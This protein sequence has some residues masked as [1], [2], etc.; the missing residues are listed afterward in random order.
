M[1]IKKKARG[2][3]TPPSREANPHNSF[4][5]FI[6]YVYFIAVPARLNIDVRYFSLVVAVAKH[7][8]NFFHAY[9]F[10][11]PNSRAHKPKFSIM[12]SNAT[13]SPRDHCVARTHTHAHADTLYVAIS[14]N[15]LKVTKKKKNEIFVSYY[16][17]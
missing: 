1:K 10:P 4:F 17:Q 12:Y 8:R 2:K 3:K 9:W 6:L 16:E 14:R 11:H 15:K 13:P 5:L 7:V